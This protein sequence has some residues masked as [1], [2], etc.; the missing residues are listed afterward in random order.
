M[1]GLKIEILS[2][3]KTTDNEQRVTRTF[4]K[5]LTDFLDPQDA[6]KTIEGFYQACCFDCSIKFH[7][8]YN[9]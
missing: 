9:K 2:I 3:D 1:Q 7:K 4:G 8:D 6:T 5:S